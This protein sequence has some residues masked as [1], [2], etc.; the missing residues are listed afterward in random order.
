MGAQALQAG[1]ADIALL[2]ADRILTLAPDDSFGH[3]LRAQAFVQTGRPSA[4]RE[5]ARLAFRHA[6]TP[7]QKHEAA[8]VAAL[9]A[10]GRERFFTAQ[11]WMRRA[12]H[13]APDDAAKAR[14][15]EEFRS[16]RRAS[17]V[18]L[19]FSASVI[20]SDNVNGGASEE[21]HVVDG[22]PIVGRLSPEAVAL[23]GT[24]LRGHAELG[25]KLHRDR[26]SETAL[27]AHMRGQAVRL[28]GEARDKAP[29]AKG[30][31]Y[32]NTIVEF[33]LH[34]RRA[35]VA[36]GPVLGFGVD[37]GRAWFG[38]AHSY[39]LKRA[40]LSLTQA[41][42]D[43]NAVRLGVN[44]Q[45]QIGIG[46][47]DKDIVNASWSLGLFHTLANDDHLSLSAFYGETDA[48]NRQ[49][50][51]YSRGLSLGY[52]RD[53]P[54]GPVTLSGSLLAQRSAYPDYSV[55]LP[56]PGGR[57]DDRVSATLNVGLHKLDVMGFIPTMSVTHER[58]TSNVSRFETT[59]NSVSFGF[60][61]EF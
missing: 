45:V 52:A 38:G 28:S 23:S 58:T 54:L 11:L 39:D 44:R 9:S 46:H 15:G 18:S 53:E 29:E 14:A 47:D 34:H 2:L 36:G 6:D 32:N 25:Y 1:R 50:I 48:D 42:G 26:R 60:K 10:A 16:V 20:P 59:T 3:F 55:I 13:H 8:R 21:I 7:V 30:E 33:G 12:L 35:T 41:L 24:I 5:P 51:R 57:K 17:K 56:V 4:A 43:R 37:I 40:S 61:S 22:L 27:R 49:A 19:S 31:N